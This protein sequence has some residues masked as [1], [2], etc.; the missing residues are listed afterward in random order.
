MLKEKNRIDRLREYQILDTPEDGTYNDMTEI[1][2]KIFNVPIAIISLVDEDRIWFKAKYGMETKEIPRSPGL[3][4]SAI[5]SDEIYLV[6]D[7]P[8]SCCEIAFDALKVVQATQSRSNEAR[9]QKLSQQLSQHYQ[10]H[11]LVKRLEM[12]LSQR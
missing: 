10:N 2:A 1:A 11:P 4:S 8:E 7:D 9:V 12:Q 5:L 6:E 3:C